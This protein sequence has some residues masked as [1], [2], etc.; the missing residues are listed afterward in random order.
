[1]CFF[2][3]FK[4]HLFCH[5]NVFLLFLFFSKPVS[6]LVSKKKKFVS[7]EKVLNK[8]VTKF[9]LLS[10][11]DLCINKSADNSGKS[12]YT[13]YK[14]FSGGVLFCLNRIEKIFMIQSCQVHE[15]TS[16]TV[17]Y[18]AE[19]LVVGRSKFRQMPIESCSIFRTDAL[20][21]IKYFSSPSWQQKKKEKIN[22]AACKYLKY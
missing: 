12:A 4:Y 5:G 22:Y 10:A 8:I 11:G 13:N 2:F 20:S 7:F 9:R 18:R 15:F 21:L 14:D 6:S 19:I 16:F 1:M 3:I 17:I